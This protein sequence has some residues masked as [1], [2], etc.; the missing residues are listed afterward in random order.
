MNTS[1]STKPVFDF[2]A[3]VEF[4][5]DMDVALDPSVYKDPAPP[6]PLMAGNYGVRFTQVG[7]KRVRKD[8][9]P[10]EEVLLL[11]D[12]KGV[13]TYPVIELKQ[14]T[15]ANAG[16]ANVGMVG[17]TAYLFQEFRTN[18]T[19]KRDFNAGGQLYDYNALSA[20]IRSHDATLGYKGLSEGIK[21]F[22]SIVAD[23]G[24]FFVN[25][26]WRAEDSKWVREQ[27]ALIDK[28]QADGEISEAEGK[29]R[30]SDVRYK[31]G[32][33]EGIKKFVGEDGSLQ[34]EWTGPSGEELPVRPYI[35]DFVSTAQIGKFRMGPR[36]I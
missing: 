19:Q 27:V 20:I 16:D 28:L 5:D 10:T 24:I 6:L 17:K 2:P 21:L 31:Q 14:I 3:N 32:Q 4:S 23:G 33:L 22:Q 36:K 8:R 12:A 15:V 7:L 9:Q 26:D 1:E 35:R 11:K 25:I 18:P 30:R 34:T 13:P 29:T